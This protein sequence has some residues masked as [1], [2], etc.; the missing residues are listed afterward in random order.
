[1]KI[2][3]HGLFVLLLTQNAFLDLHEG[4]I[5][6]NSISSFFSLTDQNVSIKSSLISQ[7]M[8]EMIAPYLISNGHPLKNRLKRLINSSMVIKNE[9][10]LAQAGFFLS[11]KAIFFNHHCNT[12]RSSW[13]ILKLY[14]D[15]EESEI[16]NVPTWKRLLIRCQAAEKIA[17][18]YWTKKSSLF[19]CSW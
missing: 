14:L 1:M 19:Y 6:Y 15:S 18:A 11:K 3:L 7:S 17:T 13:Y 9:I 5:A 10:S 2:F 16:D 12:S 4:D 8:D